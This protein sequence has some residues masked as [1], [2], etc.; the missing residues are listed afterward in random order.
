MQHLQF[1]R[2]QIADRQYREEWGVGREKKA[3]LDAEIAEN[4]LPGSPAFNLTHLAFPAT[5]E[6]LADFGLSPR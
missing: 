3:Q 6:G 4:L 1:P 2:T 5:Y